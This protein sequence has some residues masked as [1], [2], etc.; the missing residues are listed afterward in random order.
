MSYALYDIG[1]WKAVKAYVM[2]PRG[3]ILYLAAIF[4]Q[5]GVNI[6]FT[7]SFVYTTAAHAL[8]LVNLNPLWYALL[9]R[10]FLHET[11]PTHTIVALVMA[12]GCM[13]LTFVPEIIHNTDNTGD[14][15]DDTDTDTDD[16]ETQ[17]TAKGNVISIF[18]GITIALYITLI[19]KGGIEGRNMIIVSPLA[20]M[21]ASGLAFIMQRGKVLP[22]HVDWSHDR[23]VWKFWLSMSAEGTIIGVVFIA[24]AIAPRLI[25]GSEMALVL[26]LEVILGPL[27]VFLA[28]QETPSSWT[29]I[30]GFSLVLV[31]ALHEAYPIL[32]LRN[33]EESS[34]FDENEDDDGKKKDSVR[35]SDDDDGEQE[36]EA[37]GGDPTTKTPIV[38]SGE[39]ES[40]TQA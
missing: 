37:K 38:S 34:L 39:S 7:F 40:V 31:L 8:L 21:V 9:G 16:D 5:A 36:E 32:F 6:G 22:G 19:R 29:L 27:W 1:G 35:D 2:D 4:P 33:E 30:G 15:N 14:N 20:A 13:V 17:S 24:I 3:F 10:F 28:Y 25:T 18:T 11:L 12:M 23:D 26:L